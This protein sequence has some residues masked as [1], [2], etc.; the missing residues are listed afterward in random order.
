MRPGLLRWLVVLGAALVATGA[1]AAAPR[2]LRNVNGF[3]VE[4]VVVEGTRY[5][6]PREVVRA[7]GITAASNLFDDPAPWRRALLR[8]PAVL[9]VRIERRL[10]STLV[11]DVEEAEPVALARTPD[12]RPVDARGVVLP[13]RDGGV[14]VDLPVLA[15]ACNVGKDGRLRDASALAVLRT[16]A[17]I[18]VLDP[19]LAALVSEASPAE[20]GVRLDLR[21][22]LGGGVLVEDE[23]TARTLREL[24]LTLADLARRGEMDR[25]RRIDARFQEQ[26]VVLF[27]HG[28]PS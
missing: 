6:P 22:P 11:V 26:I 21:D 16:L 1:S 2:L 23:P 15:T 10:P 3:R 28:A 7:S 8:D 18:R 19:A 14:D 9:D 12:L 20:G 17:R 13:L 24:G 25:V 27:N 5:L 4:R